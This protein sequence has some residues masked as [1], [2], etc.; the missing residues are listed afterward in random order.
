MANKP[1]KDPAFLFYDGDAS[2]D[3]SHMNRLER[4]CYFDLIQAQR[5]FGAYTLDQAKKILGKDFIK[6]WPTIEMILTIDSGKYSI[7]WLSDSIEK[8]KVSSEIQRKRIQDYWD[9]IRN[10]DTAESNRNTFGIPFGTTTDIPLENEIENEF[11][12][13]PVTTTQS[14]MAID[15]NDFLT[16][17][18]WK[19]EFCMTKRIP[20]HELEAIQKQ[21]VADVKLK[22]EFVDSYK[23]YFTNWYNKA[24]PTAKI[25]GVKKMVQ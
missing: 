15:L 7:S 13:L 10:C 5:K 3:V 19:Q 1:G 21:F 18:S 25:L 14:L 16:N 9:R 11:P 23:R 22:G 4:G 24:Q 8:R 17:E 12:S 6:C 2:R 20:I